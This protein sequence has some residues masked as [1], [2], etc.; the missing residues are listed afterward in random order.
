MTQLAAGGVV[1]SS[2]MVVLIWGLLQREGRRSAEQLV[3]LL[4]AENRSLQR[5]FTA[6]ALKRETRR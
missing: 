3:D 5:D 4:I 2:F 6:A 1:F